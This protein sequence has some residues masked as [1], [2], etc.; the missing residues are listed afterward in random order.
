MNENKINNA[1]IK[2]GQA[3]FDDLDVPNVSDQIRKAGGIKHPQQLEQLL[4]ENLVLRQQLVEA[5]AEAVRA[6]GRYEEELRHDGFIANPFV[7]ADEL[8]K[9]AEKKNHVR[10]I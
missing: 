2:H 7:Y 4:E 10:P 3:D 8:S 5:Q 9:Q 6:Y 1:L